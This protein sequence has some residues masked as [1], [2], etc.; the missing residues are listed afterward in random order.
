MF[1]GTWE[2]RGTIANSRVRTWASNV[3]GCSESWAFHCRAITTFNGISGG[4]S[5]LGEGLG[6]QQ[7]FNPWI[8]TNICGCTICP[9][10]TFHV[11]WG[12]PRKFSPCL[13]PYLYIWVIPSLFP[14][15]PIIKL[16]PPSEGCPQRKFM[17]LKLCLGLFATRWGFWKIF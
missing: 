4:S 8:S 14:S 17:E 11:G 5:S 15:S 13:S 12:K 16:Q 1:P 3:G 6:W 7:G 10:S 9:L 2:K